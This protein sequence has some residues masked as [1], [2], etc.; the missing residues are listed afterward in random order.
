MN[1]RTLLGFLSTSNITN[2]QEPETKMPRP[3]WNASEEFKSDYTLYVDTGC[4]NLNLER[5][6]FTLFVVIRIYSYMLYFMEWE[7]SFSRK[8]VWRVWL[9][10]CSFSQKLQMGKFYPRLKINKYILENI[11]IDN[12]NDDDDDAFISKHHQSLRE[13]FQTC[14]K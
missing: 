7:I 6:R 11:S 14:N 12:D 1:N 13:P 10:R 8:R 4:L 2:T 9:H 5:K 3:S